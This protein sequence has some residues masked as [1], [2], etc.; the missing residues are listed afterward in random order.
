[1]A[2]EAEHLIHITPLRPYGGHVLSANFCLRHPMPRFEHA[3]ATI[4][5]RQWR[6][7]RRVRRGLGS[8][9]VDR[10]P[11]YRRLFWAVELPFILVRNATIPPVEADSWSQAQA[12]VG[13]CFELLPWWHFCFL[14][15]V[16]VVLVAAAL[17]DVACCCCCC[18]ALSCRCVDV[19]VIFSLY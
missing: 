1:M 8:S 17:D 19:A 3:W 18:L 5:W 12:A 15:L 4:Q 2:N 13:F 7:R 11:W 10:L 14:R 6:L 9:E 16:A